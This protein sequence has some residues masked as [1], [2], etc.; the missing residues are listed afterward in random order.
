MVADVKLLL[1]RPLVPQLICLTLALLLIWQIVTGVSSFFSLDKAMA[2]RHDQPIGPEK[3][4]KQGGLNKGLKTAFFGDY[5]P[6]NISDAEVKQSR[7]DLTV[8]GIIF[9]DSE[10]AS[11]V[12][13]RTADGQEKT[14]GIGE[15]LPGDVI[16]KRITSDGVL[17]GRNGSLERLSLPKNAL[18]FDPPA[19]PLGISE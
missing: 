4:T 2:V 17:I 6:K 19:E 16:I 9:S 5:V 14:F 13:I 1:S 18:I 11:H 7:L 10:E 8:V 12:I 3:N 15:T